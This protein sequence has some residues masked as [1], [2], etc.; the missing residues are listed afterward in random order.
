MY[1][2]LFIKYPLFLQILIKI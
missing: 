1:T 2:G